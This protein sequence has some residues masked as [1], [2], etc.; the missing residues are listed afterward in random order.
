M[1]FLPIVVVGYFLCPRRYRWLLLLVA[2]YGFYISWEPRFAILMLLSTVVDYFAALNMSGAGAKKKKL[3]L[4]FSLM[5]N[6]GLLFFFKYKYFF[7]NFLQGWFGVG[8][9]EK[10]VTVILIP[11]GISFYTFQ[12]LGYTIDVFRGEKAPEKHFGY[13]ALFVSF[14]PQ[15]VSGPIERSSVLLPQLKDPAKFHPKTFTNGL[16]LILWG[17]FLKVIADRLGVF[18]DQVFTNPDAYTGAPVLGAVYFFTLQVFYDF[19]AYTNIAIGSAMLLGINLS[20]NFKR[21]YLARSIQEFWSRWHITLTTWMRDYLYFSMGGNR[22][23][24]ERY[25]F[26][27]YVVFLAVAIWH[28][29]DPKL[30]LFGTLHFLYYLFGKLTRSTRKKIVKSLRLEQNFLVCKILPIMITFH[31][32]AFTWVVWWSPGISEM[33]TI[34]ENAFHLTNYSMNGLN[35][36]DNLS[37]LGFTF[38]GIIFIQLV[39]LLQ[40]NIPERQFLNHRKKWLRWTILYLLIFGILFLEVDQGGRAFIYFQF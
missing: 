33:I 30:I 40:G 22:V 8:E 3:W 28:G 4:A 13:F 10:L 20:D 9:P 35:I 5:T 16:K 12:S 17:L 31:L 11:I 37:F 15:L 19:S 26:N 36:I 7:D 29:T 27:L 34:F 14:F 24:F 39:F 6:L 21:P 23:N 25:L 38:L 18:V 2:S 1:L 32:V